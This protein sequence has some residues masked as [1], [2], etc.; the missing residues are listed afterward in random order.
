ML[1]T[2]GSLLDARPRSIA[3]RD[4][5]RA[6]L[7]ALVH[8]DRPLVYAVHGIA[9]IGKSTLLE[10]FSADA[11]AAGAATVT[12]D[13]REIEPTERGFL[14]QLAD[15]L[16][17]PEAPLAETASALAMLGERVVLI[18]DTFELLGLLD[19]W[20][21][22]T[23]VPALPANVRVLLAGRD[24]PSTWWTHTYGDL[25]CTMR[26]EN[27]AAPDAEAWLRAAGADPGV[28]R[29]A[30]GHP[31]TLQL[32]ASALRDRPGV[33]IEDAALHTVVEEVARV[34]LDNLDPATRR[35]LDAASVVR[36]TTL[37]VLDAMLPEE[38]A[39][40]AFERLRALPFVELG[41]DGLVVHDTM[42][43]VTAMLLRASD[44]AAHR[45]YRIAA[46]SRLRAELRGASSAELWRY[47]ADVIYLVDNPVVRRF[48]FPATVLDCTVEAARPDDWPA[49]EALGRD[50]R[51]L[52]MTHLED[53]WRALP[54]S[55]AVARHASGA[56]IGFRCLAERDDVSADLA[57]RDPLAARWREHLRRDPVPRSGRV[58]Y[59]RYVATETDRDTPSPAL[60]ALL[61]EVTRELI[62][63]R[64]ELRR[65]YA[66]APPV[67]GADGMCAMAFGYVPLPGEPDDLPY[68]DRSLFND[69]GPG[70]VDGWLT[71]LAAR[72]LLV[73]D[74][75]AGVDPVRRELRVD[76]DRVDLTQ[77]EFDV[78][79]YLEQHEGRPV[80]RE[81]LLRDVWGY[82]WTG[83]SNVVEVAISALRKKLGDRARALRTVRGVGYALDPLT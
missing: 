21:S 19:G 44:P 14:A 1:A 37:S 56:V 78:L 72:E 83:G 82:E 29:F 52:D 3:G 10:A 77:L 81:A 59:L 15:A 8:D 49:I 13:A 24:R 30:H 7:L 6:A 58:L 4:R 76:G 64:P 57:R 18:V 60:A 70:S 31:L 11:R 62:G 17:R 39:W 36:R 50:E 69:L 16:G 66:P 41:A 79:R 73:E 38:P 20:L 47:T 9:G 71:D 12:L 25:M 2:L 43:A 55:F 51:E 63:M 40:E 61:L 34:Y 27:L 28:N 48:F 33:D 22:R 5:D 32:A 67:Y 35:A 68:A 42:R 74:D 53:W 46:W 26:L 45:R 65:T 54:E 23:F 75:A 80:R